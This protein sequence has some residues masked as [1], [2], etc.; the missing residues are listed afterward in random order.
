MAVPVA[1]IEWRPLSEI[2]HV[3]IE[4]EMR[5]RVSVQGDMLVWSEVLLESQ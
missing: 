5:Q 3:L 1:R 4:E 2:E